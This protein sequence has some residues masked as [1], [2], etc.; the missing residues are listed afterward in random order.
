MS[1][2]TTLRMTRTYDAPAERVFN[3]WTS[4]DVMRRWFRG[5]RH[6]DTPEAEVDLRVGGAVR[7][8]MRDPQEDKRYGGGGEYTVVDPP[9]R[10]AFTWVWDDEPHETLIE[11]E[12][13]EAD[14]VTTV[15][16]T[17]SGL[18]SEEAIRSHEEG[19]GV[20]FDNLE[21]VLAAERPG[22]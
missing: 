6:F 5:Q 2:K 15:N 19:W 22:E 17:H 1:A 12:F 11:I 20:C 4:E 9:R 14:G 7:V 18:W 21:R 10:L 16:F 8:V 3:A 13:E